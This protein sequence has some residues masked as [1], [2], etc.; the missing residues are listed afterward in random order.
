MSVAS[1]VR[2]IGHR[3]PVIVIWAILLMLGIGA[4]ERAWTFYQVW[5]VDQINQVDVF[6]YASVEYVETTPDGLAMVSTAAWHLPV[7]RVVWIDVLRC[8]GAVFSTLV[9]QA[10]A[11]GPRSFTEAAWVYTNPHPIGQRCQMVSTISAE[12]R[13][14]VFTQVIESTPFIPSDEEATP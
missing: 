14:R 12:H 10:G 9:N 13:G 4:V 1:T 8:D 3:S 7:D 5:E 2:Y 6:E 11:R